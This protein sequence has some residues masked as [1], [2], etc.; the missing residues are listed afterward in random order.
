MLTPTA[1]LF[2]LFNLAQSQVSNTTAEKNLVAAI[3]GNTY[4]RTIRPSDKVDVSISYSLKQIIGIDE[5]NQILTSSG[6][7]G[8]YWT[9]SRLAWTPA[10]YNDIEVVMVPLKSIWVPDTI[11]LN[12]AEGDGYLKINSDFSYVSVQYTGVVYFLSQSL[13]MKTRCAMDVKNYPFDTQ[14]CKLRITSWSNGDNRINYEIK[15][16]YVDVSDYTN[17]TIWT[18]TS[19][20]ITNS[21]SSD[22]VPF[23]DTVNTEIIMILVLTRKSLYYMM[24]TV[25]PC[26]ILNIV[27]LLTFFMPFGNQ[28]GLAMTGFLTFSV[29][30]LRIASDI[31]VQSDYLPKISS[32]FISS[33]SFN[34]IAMNWFVI[35]NRFITQGSMPRFLEIICDLL[36]KIFCYCFPEEKKSLNKTKPDN[37]VAE[38]GEVKVNS[39]SPSLEQEKSSEAYKQVPDSKCRHCDRCDVC[40]ADHTKEKDKNKKKKDIESRLE[41]MN[42]LCFI[43]MFTVMLITQLAI[44]TTLS[45]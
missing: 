33:I 27:T 40:Q 18:L 35:R 19:T 43:I 10:T 9:D 30:S 8:Q 29:Y 41:A 44:W 15:D 2:L 36:K 22:R 39:V 17:N 24:N 26:F 23:E 14:T 37:K 3:L 6:Y 42:Y 4:S 38:N 1:I 7:I 13:A 34:L 45:V 32:Y 12:S 11:I 20:D 16:A 25:L 5:K 21:T 28:I 31:P